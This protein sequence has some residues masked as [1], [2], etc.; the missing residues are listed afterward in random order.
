RCEPS[1]LLLAAKEQLPED[2]RND[3]ENPRQPGA[4]VQSVDLR[5]RRVSGPSKVERP[6]NDKS[7]AW[8]NGFC[9]VVPLQ[10]VAM[11][12]RIELE[13]DRQPPDRTRTIGQL[14]VM[15]EAIVAASLVQNVRERVVDHVG[16]ALIAK[17]RIGGE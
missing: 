10:R 1:E 6:A 14:A 12:G 15:L 8:R 3:E 7:T 9:L 4:P 17:R 2:Q 11:P 16:D 13:I 5:L